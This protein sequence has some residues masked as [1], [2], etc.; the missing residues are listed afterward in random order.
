[1]K[2]SRWVW[3]LASLVHA[4]VISFVQQICRVT[5]VRAYMQYKLDLKCSQGICAEKKKKKEDSTAEEVWGREKQ[6]QYR[7]HF[8]VLWFNFFLYLFVLC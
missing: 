2:Q 3:Q 7:Q 4:E 5:K 6:Q 8:S 1:M